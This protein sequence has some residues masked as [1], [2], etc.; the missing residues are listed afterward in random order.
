MNKTTTSILIG[1]FIANSSV[2]MAQSYSESS[3]THA[4]IGT[5]T[6]NSKSNKIDE[7]NRATTAQDQSNASADIELTKKIR[8]SIVADESLSTYAHNVKIVSV[9]GHVTLNG[10]VR[11]A[12]EKS[13]IEKKAV[14][15]AGKTMVTSELKIAPKGS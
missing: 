1:L 7:S 15:I 3:S 14:E 13:T 8:Q 2:V 6:D 5:A 4:T 12:P 9:K 11:S 10:V